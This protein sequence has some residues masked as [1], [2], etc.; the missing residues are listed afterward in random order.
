MPVGGGS[1]HRS[2]QLSDHRGRRWFLK[3]NRSDLHDAFRAEEDGL[4]ALRRC[5]E[6]A[7]PAP[8]GSGVCEDGAWLLMEWLAFAP[9]DGTSA[10]AL[11][12]GL[13]ALHRCTEEL[14]GWARDNFIGA[15]P[16]RNDLHPDWATFYRECRLVPQ[17]ELAAQNGAPRELLRAGEVVLVRAEQLLG[18]HAP[19]PSLLHGDLWSGNCAALADG[20]PAVF[21]PAVYAGDRETD[22][23]MTR[24]FGGF[25]P[26]FYAAYA[27]A[28]PLPEGHEEREPLYRLYHVL[29]HY[30][31][32]GD[33]YLGQARSLLDTLVT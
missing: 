14:H 12:R 7:V 10:R 8:Q 25:P 28:S 18:G 3:T 20:T 22:L 32:F 16:Q 30:N 13:A 5:T 27:S 15:T 17:L 4:A 26:A 21:D 23:A 1:I 6:L 2:W 9:L 31:L 24:L 29:N 11:G 19:V 33:A